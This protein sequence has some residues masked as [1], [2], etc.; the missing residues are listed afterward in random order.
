MKPIKTFAVLTTALIAFAAPVAAYAEVNLLNVS[1]D[2]TRELYQDYNAAFAKYWKGKGGDTVTVKQS[3]GGSGK[4]ARAV[5]DG[6]D[7]DVVTL[8]LAYDID[9]IGEKAKLIPESWQK[10]LPHNS[11]PYTSTIVFLVR[12]GNPKKVKDWNDLVRPD[13]KVITPNPKTSGGARWN[14]LAAWGY[15]LKQKGGSEAKAKEFVTR[16]FKNVPVLDS[17]A[18]G[19]TTTFVQRGQGDVL[20]AWENEAFLAVNELGKDKFEIV[21]PSISIL[22]EPPVTVVDKVVD[23]KGTRKVAEEYL[24]YLYT[25]AGQEIAAKHYYRPIDKK[26][27]ARYAKVFPKVKLFTIDDTFGGWKAAQKKHFADGGVFDQIYGP[28]K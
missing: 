14:Y 19:S 15:A 10:R 1:Y 23:R 13:V 27:A 9:E 11:S 4:Q 16:L 8:A 26:V 5:I 20:L 7:A 22:A 12:K 2:P 28:G 24:K 21:V 6:L 17:G 25:P 18:R 3:H